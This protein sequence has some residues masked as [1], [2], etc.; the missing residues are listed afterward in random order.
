VVTSGIDGIYPKGFVIGQVESVRRGTGDLG[1]VIVKPTVDFRSLESVLV[2]LTP[3][4]PA[5]SEIEAAGKALPAV[6]P[7]E[8]LQPPA[9]PVQ[10]TPAPAETTDQDRRED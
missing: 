1:S 10:A 5:G 8:S 7:T 2:I 3:P 6:P 9:P 4:P